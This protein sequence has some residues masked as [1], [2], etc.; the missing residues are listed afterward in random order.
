MLFSFGESEKN[1]PAA[2]CRGIWGEKE[3]QSSSLMI[4]YKKRN[5]IFQKQDPAQNKQSYCLEKIQCRKSECLVHNN[6]PKS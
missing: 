4:L 5:I 1:P 6:V 3:S 2:S